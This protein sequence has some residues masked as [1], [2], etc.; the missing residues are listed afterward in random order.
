MAVSNMLPMSIMA[1]EE[2]L[3]IQNIT[4]T[5]KDDSETSKKDTSIEG[6]A[7]SL[8]DFSGEGISVDDQGNVKLSRL[9]NANDNFAFYKGLKKQTKDFHFSTDVLIAAG[10]ANSAGILFG[11]KNKD[12]MNQGWKAANVVKEGKHPAPLMRVFKVPNGEDY[13][14][15]EIEDFDLTKKIHLDLDV[16]EDGSFVYK[17][18]SEGGTENIQSGKIDNWEGGFVGLLAYQTEAVF[19][20]VQ[21]ENREKQ[22]ESLSPNLENLRGLGGT[23]QKKEDGS[24]YSSGGGDNFAIS[25]TKIANFVYRANIKNEGNKGAGALMFRVQNPDNPKGGCYVVN[26][27]YSNKIFKIFEFPSGGTIKQVSLSSVNPKEDGSYD[28]EVY[29]LGED[30]YI[31]VNGKIIMSVKLKSYKDG[32]LGLLTWDGTA[33]YKNVDY[34]E[35]TELPEIKKAE[36]TSFDI[37]TEGVTITPT[38]EKS[39]HNYAMDI[40]AGMQEVSLNAKADGDV[41]YTLLDRNDK[42]VVENTK[43]EDDFTLHMKD[44]TNN[45][46]KM[47]ITVE[48]ENAR[49]SF[50]FAI[51]QWI[52]TDELAKDPNRAQ[53]HVS[54]ITNFM[55]DPN[56][57]VY[58]S[59]DGYWHL[60]YQY[61]TAMGFKEQSWAHV[62]S[63]DLVNWEQQP[64]GLQ[65]D[66]LGL[67]FS[68]SA[69]EDRENTSGF[70]TDNKP[71]ESKLVHIFTYANGPQEQG[72]AYSKDHGTTWTKYAG[73]PVITNEEGSISGGDFRD[74]KVFKVEGDSK[75]YMI[76]AGG[77]A[78]IFTSPDLKTWTRS[79]ALK[80][81]NGDQIHS[82]CPGLIPVKVNGNGE[83][84]W[85]YNGSA[86]FYIVGSMKKEGDTYKWTAETEKMDIDSNANPWGGFGKYA[87]MTFFEDGT[88]KGREIGISWLQDFT[89]F[90]GKTYMGTQSLPQ[91]FGLK[92][93][94]DGNYIVTTNPVEEV[95]KLR[96]ENHV[97][98][99]TK[100]KKVDADS[101]N[102]LSGISGIRYDLEGVFTIGTA[103][104]FGFKLR[105]GNGKELIYKYNVEE[106]KMVL[107]GSNA[108]PNQGGGNFSYRL[109][110]LANGKVKL[111]VIIDQ[112]A[113][114]AFG[115]DGE[116]NISTT[117]YQDNDNIG[118]EFFTVD[119][120]VTIDSLDI[121]D[122]KSM[123][124]G[125]SGSES[126]DAKLFLSVQGSVGG[127][128]ERN[129]EFTI[130]SNIYPNLEG[131]Q[132]IEWNYDGLTLIKKENGS[133]T[134]KATKEGAY[135]ITGTTE[136]GSLS[137]EITIKV[138]PDFVTNVE[139]PTDKE[140]WDS[141][142]YGIVGKNTGGDSFLMSDEKIYTNQPFVLETN[143]DIQNGLAAGIV[144]GVEDKNDVAKHWFCA[145]IDYERGSVKLFKNENGQK[146]VEEAPLPK[147]SEGIIKKAYMV[148][149]E[150]DG[151][152]TLYYYLDDQLIITKEN[153]EFTDGF[154]GIQT[155]KSETVFNKTFVYTN[156]KATNVKT[157]IDDIIVDCKTTKE[158]V[159]A[160]LPEKVE[161]NYSNDI[162]QSNVVTWNTDALDMSQAGIYQVTG[163][164]GGFT[165]TV[166]IEVRV[167]KT[168]L[169]ETYDLYKDYKQVDYTKSS[170]TVFKNA[171]DD[172]KSKLDGT[173][174]QG[175]V[176]LAES[177]LKEA[178]ADLV[179]AANKSELVL[180]LE[181]AKNIKGEGFTKE[182]YQNLLDAVKVAEIVYAD[183]D[184][185]DADV[186][187]QVAALTDAILNLKTE[188]GTPIIVD[189]SKLEEAINRAGKK[190]EA[191]YTA[192]SW[193][194]FM[195]ALNNAKAVFAK[196]TATQKEVFEA[197]SAL[198]IAES[199]LR[200]S[201]VNPGTD[202]DGNDNHDTDVNTGDSTN[203]GVLSSMLVLSGAAIIVM[204][205]S[206]KKSN[207]K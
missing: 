95:E 171:L 38:F 166:N 177:A 148:R 157:V 43:I 100:N 126:E 75:W 48:T 97:L 79:Q 131:N 87:T 144:F 125:K 155:F 64:H 142:Q 129:K 139:W 42:V 118:M 119:G 190:D 50:T 117:L 180:M 53:F 22:G 32:N 59:T 110:P 160:M 133:I 202:G 111:R 192:D 26:I 5:Q 78:Q 114:E 116:A 23:W 150:Y 34:E 30:A 153:A 4:D 198:L 90:E 195:G 112:G 128:V 175:E 135:T 168:S 120:D 8:T 124:S 108:G 31:F 82:E 152:G 60:F 9:S 52:S 57:M 181:T 136:D 197:L 205:K 15:K 20:D 193:K 68:G 176:D 77:A 27:D 173:A 89:N 162:T 154:V 3:A 49:D 85:I 188:D 164:A 146:W 55:N 104:E 81:K 28:L 186:K 106:K 137:R 122:M 25:D 170:W 185:I 121:Y 69:V 101:K 94:K 143:I 40:P 201:S 174:T 183:G 149:I 36:L 41:F 191:G 115:N 61:S 86:G 178:G 46:M 47:I 184:A 17:V 156:A 58:D 39:V 33:V 54:P 67:I 6:K 12:A 109:T 18:K 123:Y 163:R 147:N 24:I 141:K 130:E 10:G 132:K 127:N 14:A 189:K 63:K 169:K 105:K 199:E 207:A 98:Y 91:E 84:K 29:A 113:V 107:N 13:T 151:V 145:N 73:N 187:V 71:G 158:E 194:A 35:A 159:L 21:F 19:S 76:T 96:D 51:T 65:I 66:E 102:I 2:P 37:L 92:Q 1:N 80:Y 56:G 161:I 167:N 45:F 182:S 93:D 70:F 99:R 72:I 206:K 11:V 179:K 140:A 44:F 138:K 165:V 203:L 172:A 7:S 74:P 62:R 83:T 196:E 103:K 16:K 204:K 88:G 134:L 200:I